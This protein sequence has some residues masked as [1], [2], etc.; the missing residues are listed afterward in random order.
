ML[1]KQCIKN[2]LDEENGLDVRGEDREL[3]SSG[4]HE[5]VVMP[6]FCDWTDG[7]W[8][9]KYKIRYQQKHC[10]TKGCRKK[11]RT[12]CKCSMGVY[13]CTECYWKHIQD[14]FKYP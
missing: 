2:T 1:A 8:K 9:K 3:R 5:R 12:F 6:P 10:K 11:T 14:P 13:R 4:V 7:G